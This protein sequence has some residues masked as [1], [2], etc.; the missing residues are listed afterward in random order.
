M[1]TSVLFEIRREEPGNSKGTRLTSHCSFSPALDHDS[2]STPT[3]QPWHGYTNAPRGF[4]RNGHCGTRRWVRLWVPCPAQSQD[5]PCATTLP[6]TGVWACANVSH[7]GTRQAVPVG[8]DSK[9]LPCVTLATF[10]R[11]LKASGPGSKHVQNG[12]RPA[13]LAPGSSARG[14]SSPESVSPSVRS[15]DRACSQGPWET[16]VAGAL[17][18]APTGEGRSQH[19]LLVLN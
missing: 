18:G 4:I 12:E 8:G 16:W 17:A 11:L 15:N 10:H 9:S 1:L 5:W 3:E 7:S 6:N 14:S 19:S 2:L 13:S